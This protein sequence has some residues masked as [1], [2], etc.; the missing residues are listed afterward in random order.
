MTYWEKRQ[1]QLNKQLEKDEAKLK[2]RLSSFYDAEFRKLERHIAAYY[3]Q[4]GENSVIEYRKLMESLPAED[5][6]LL[7]EQMDAFAK[8]YPEYAHLMPVRESIYKLNRL[9]GL[10]YS[11]LMQQYEIGAANIEQITN[12]L[13]RQGLR[14]ANAAAESLGYGKN[15]YA[16]NADIIKKFVDVPWADGKNFSTRIW[17]NAEK[18]ANYLNTDIAQA[19]AR[20]D[21]Y[22]R[23]VSNLKK[24]FDKVTRND[25]YR[26]VYTEGTYVMAEATMTPFESEF[27]QYRVSTV[28]DGKVCD[29][30]REVAKET[31]QIKDRKPGI[32][33]PPLHTWC[34]C[35]F[36]IAVNDWDTWMEDYERRHGNGHAEKVKDRLNDESEIA[37]VFHL[38][39]PEKGG[40][41]EDS[42]LLLK[43][44][45]ELDRYY[46]VTGLHSDGKNFYMRDSKER[47]VKKFTP[48]QLA[49][50]IRESKSYKGQEVKI[51]S[52]DA[53]AEGMTAAQELANAL[54]VPVKAPIA[55]IGLTENGRFSVIK[56]LNEYGYIVEQYEGDKGWKIFIPMEK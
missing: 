20:G 40:K 29:I 15:F 13:T 21:S 34:R 55:L 45:T 35:S 50:I 37:T 28:G 12:H 52:C 17:G 43:A 24:R 56:S 6:R 44:R 1:Q 48:E 18:L 5:R 10:Q 2:E 38:N 3:T 30:C 9:E 41:L 32:N 22:D 47:I 26:L 27:E 19:F 51:Y 7:M 49:K 53:G 16:A 23:I 11:I 25:A 8:K 39:F 4:Y 36:T 54:G 33:F 31:F 42:E 46:Q 14:A